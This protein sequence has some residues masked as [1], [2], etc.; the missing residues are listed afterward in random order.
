MASSGHLHAQNVWLHGVQRAAIEA[1]LHEMHG[2][3]LLLLW[4]VETLLRRK[5]ERALKLLL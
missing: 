5:K 4:H 2:K 3:K 1:H